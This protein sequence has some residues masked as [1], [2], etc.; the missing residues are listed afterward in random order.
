MEVIG[1]NGME[2]SDETSSFM[3]ER[4]DANEMITLPRLK[5]GFFS[6]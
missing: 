2:V 3:N 5:L 1:L 6:W 4:G